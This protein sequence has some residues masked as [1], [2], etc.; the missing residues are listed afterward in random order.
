MLGRTL[1]R[2]RGSLVLSLGDQ[3]RVTPKRNPE[4]KSL[5][6]N[7][8]RLTMTTKYSF[9]SSTQKDTHKWINDKRVKAMTKVIENAMNNNRLTEKL[10]KKAVKEYMTTMKELELRLYWER[11]H[12]ARNEARF[13]KHYEKFFKDDVETLPVFL[14]AEYNMAIKNNKQESQTNLAIPEE[15]NPE[16]LYWEQMMRLNSEEE[17]KLKL[18][19]MRVRKIM[20]NRLIEEY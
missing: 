10:D 8:Q 16:N 14:K 13:N 11:M 5:S 20:E 18:L 4:K 6:K 2:A 19:Q 17:A 12:Y 1:G 15:F 3:C 9:N 7:Y